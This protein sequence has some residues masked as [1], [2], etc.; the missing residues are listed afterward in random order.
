[1]EEVQDANFHCGPDG[2]Q[3]DPDEERP[4]DVSLPSTPGCRGGGG[5]DGVSF[6]FFGLFTA[7]PDDVLW[8]VACLLETAKSCVF[9][10]S[11]TVTSQ[12]LHMRRR[13]WWSRDLRCL[14]RCTYPVP[15]GRERYC[16]IVAS[17]NKAVPKSYLSICEYLSKNTVEILL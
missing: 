10:P 12:H 15:K 8:K 9:P 1:M 4:P 11:M 13:W 2:W 16:H 7:D 5:G 14:N 6:L 17:T 3:L